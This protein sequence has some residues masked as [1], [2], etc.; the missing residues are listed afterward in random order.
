MSY[1]YRLNEQPRTD[2]G[3]RF[4]ELPR[5]PRSASTV[6]SRTFSSWL[7][8]AQPS[9]TQSRVRVWS[10]R[11]VGSTARQPTGK[12]GRSGIE[13]GLGDEWIGETK[14][15]IATGQP[16]PISDVL[17]RSLRDYGRIGMVSIAALTVMAED[18]AALSLGDAVFLGHLMDCSSQLFKVL[19]DPTMSSWQ[20]ED[21]SR[22]RQL[23]ESIRIWGTSR[24]L[25]LDIVEAALNGR[26]AR[27]VD[28][29]YCPE[30]KSG[31]KRVLNRD[32]TLEVVEK[33]RLI[34]DEFE[35]WVWSDRECADSLRV[36]YNERF[37][38]W[39]PRGIVGSILEF[40]G[41]ANGVVCRG[42][43]PPKDQRWSPLEHH[44][45]SAG[46]PRSSLCLPCMT[47]SAVSVVGVSLRFT[48]PLPSGP[49]S[50]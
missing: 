11:T 47:P 24:I 14:P 10:T 12:G 22:F 13:I 8:S 48:S 28:E 42:E 32:L 9:A 41:L 35:I 15:Q 17:V 30:S 39:I 20:I 3:N 49:S 21:K 38:R 44:K 2:S 33:Q 40:P 16:I 6:V 19:H 46:N 29:V 5:A 23:P 18:E 27:V 45:P 37:C 1:D 34:C 7:T 36:L 50:P 43:V 4:D 26:P 31:I 25:A